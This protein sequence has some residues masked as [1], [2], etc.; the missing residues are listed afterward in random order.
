M[1][2]SDLNV[3]VTVC[4]LSGFDIDYI[5]E[6]MRKFNEIEAGIIFGS[7]AKGNYRKGSDVDLAIVGP[8]LTPDVVVRLHALLEDEGPLPYYFDIVD[9][10]H[11]GD[12]SVKDH[13]D[14]VGLTIYV[15]S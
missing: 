8:C 5:T 6:S 10:T 9:Y 3:E 2:N 4:G 7:R 14:R 1:G 13:I 15:R 12:Q 11:C